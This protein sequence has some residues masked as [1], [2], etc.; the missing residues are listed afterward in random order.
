MLFIMPSATAPAPHFG[1]QLDAPAARTR[2]RSLS[3]FA[4]MDGLPAAKRRKRS[5][6]L[7]PPPPPRQLNEDPYG[8][9]VRDDLLAKELAGAVRPRLLL[10]PKLA[11]MRR[12]CLEWIIK[13]RRLLPETV[14]LGASLFDRFLAVPRPS[15]GHGRLMVTATAALAC[16]FK[17]EERLTS[18]SLVDDLVHESERSPFAPCMRK[19]DVLDSEASLLCACAFDLSTISPVHFLRRFLHETDLADPSPFNASCRRRRVLSPP[20]SATTPGSSSS[21]SHGAPWSVQSRALHLLELTLMPTTMAR[22]RPSLMAAAALHVSLKQLG[23]PKWAPELKASTGYS[24]E[25][26]KGCAE[27][28]TQLAASRLST[29]GKPTTLLSPTTVPPPAPKK[30]MPR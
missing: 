29:Q 2:S 24:A 26:L 9:C 12:R 14:H 27:E 21:S 6:P 20:I 11:D 8:A 10:D 3:L 22:W 4:L 13:D 17:Y 7:P 16:A 25:Q 19:R 28:L 15:L 5:V 18:P 30:R 23:L 1:S